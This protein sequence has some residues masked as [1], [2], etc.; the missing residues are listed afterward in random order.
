[1]TKRRP[2]ERELHIH[3]VPTPV[4]VEITEDGLSFRIPGTRS[5]VRLS[6]YRAVE[7]SETEVN[8]P[9]FLMGRPLELLKYK[10]GKKAEK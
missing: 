4:V 7:S 2:I 9:S 8:V 5:R 6:W 1:M 10:A 3:G